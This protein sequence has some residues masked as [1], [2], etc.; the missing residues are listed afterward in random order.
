M[1]MLSENVLVKEIERKSKIH[2]PDKQARIPNK[3]VVVAVG[4][5]GYYGYNAMVKTTVKKGDKVA[6]SRDKAMEIEL[7]G[8]NYY[9]LQ[10][11]DVLGILT[12]EEAV[13]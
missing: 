4:P 1:K 7:K 5:G 3:G 11:R 6:F 9:G 12:D 10:E 13:G 2:I 8:V